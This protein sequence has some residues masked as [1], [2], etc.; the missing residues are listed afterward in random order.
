MAGMIGH[1]RVFDVV[2][3]ASGVMISLKNASAITYVVEASST[4]S[5]AVVAAKTYGGGT[6][7]WVPANGFG[8]PSIW[9]QN[10]TPSNT[11]AWSKQTSVWTTNSVA[12]AQTNTYVS[13]ICFYT[14]E[15]ADGFDYI[16][17]TATDATATFAILHDLTVQRTPPNLAILGA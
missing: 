14:S 15:F 12:L 13:T 6:T 3:V 7:T 9:Y 16:E 11:A 8:Q 10:A 4:S 1:G 2:A 5:L 17:A